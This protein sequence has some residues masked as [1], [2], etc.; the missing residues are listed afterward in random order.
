MEKVF[1]TT[2][3]EIKGMRAI[4]SMKRER[5]K[6]YFI[7]KMARKSTRVMFGMGVYMASEHHMIKMK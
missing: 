2:R 7:E 1:T 3:M 6:E 5:A 4:T